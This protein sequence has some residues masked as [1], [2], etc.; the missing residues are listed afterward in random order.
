MK[1]RTL[2]GLAQDALQTAE[3]ADDG[4]ILTKQLDGKIYKEVNLVLTEL[5]GKW[6][7]RQMKHLFP[8]DTDWQVLLFERD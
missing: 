5:G 4:L 7:S 3:F 2:S 6:N 1:K 8:T